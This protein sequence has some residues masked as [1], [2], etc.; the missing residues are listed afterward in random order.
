IRD[1]HVTGVQTC[2]L[3]IC[4]HLGTWNAATAPAPAAPS[5]SGCGTGLKL[6]LLGLTDPGACDATDALRHRASCGA[7]TRDSTDATL[8]NDRSEERR[9][10]KE[11]TTRWS[12]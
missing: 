1:F 10:G 2:A 12:T 11:G 6:S 9:V 7:M 3:P 5:H 8:F 4:F